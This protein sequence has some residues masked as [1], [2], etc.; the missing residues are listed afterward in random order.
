MQQCSLI[1][2]TFG[3]SIF[4][5][6]IL[7]STFRYASFRVCYCFLLPEI[8]GEMNNHYRNFQVR[9]DSSAENDEKEPTII[10]L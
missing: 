3:F 1:R 8:E 9:S 5:V 10:L 4:P 2:A 6:K 7:V